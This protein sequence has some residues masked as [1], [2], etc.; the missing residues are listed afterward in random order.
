[1]Y[2]K[3]LFG[4][5]FVL[6]LQISLGEC[7][8]YIQSIPNKWTVTAESWNQVDN[9]PEEQISNS[10]DLMYA[11][12]F[13]DPDRFRE[14]SFFGP[15]AEL[16]WKITQA[17]AVFLRRLYLA[18]GLGNLQYTDQDNNIN[19]CSWPFPVAT[20]LT[21]GQRIMIILKGV[22][23]TEFLEFLSSGNQGLYEKRSFSSHGVIF[24]N[25]Q[26]QEIKIKSSFRG[27]SSR[28][29]NLSLNFALGWVGSPLP[30]GNYVYVD[31]GEFCAQTKSP[32]PKRQL[33]HLLIFWKQFPDQ[34]TDV[35]LI[36]L[37]GC[38]PGCSNIFGCSHNFLSGFAKQK[39]RRSSTGGVKWSQLSLGVPPPAE[40]GGKRL[41]IDRE[42]FEYLKQR[43]PAILSSSEKDQER[44]FRLFL[45]RDSSSC[46]PLLKTYN[47][48]VG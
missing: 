25:G 9:P 29:G 13:Q 14:I 7:P 27:F 15:T 42:F 22:P 48:W 33:G 31:G 3:I 39:K 45:A 16:A 38:A 41:I 35:L 47:Q 46:S 18:L 4:F 12:L 10:V 11:T 23:M 43:I 1:M 2:K 21:Q 32:L 36:G 44:L 19:T 26:F 5:I 20:A 37:E 34:N 6:C 8:S 28:E 40:Y 30:N 24:S 17:K